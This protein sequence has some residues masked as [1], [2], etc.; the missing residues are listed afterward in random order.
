MSKVEPVSTSDAATASQAFWQAQLASHLAALFDSADPAALAELQAETEWVALRS[1][2]VLFRRGDPGSAAYTVLSGRLRVIDDTAG[3]RALNEIGA[4]EIL[5]EMALLSA[6]RRSATVLAV[7]DSLLARL[8]AA[9]FHRLIERQPAVLR[10]ISALLVDRLRQQSAAGGRARPVVRT[11]AVV[12]ASPG[13]DTEGFVRRLVGAL[14]LHGATLH[15][16]A[17]LVDRAL[18]QDGIAR[19]AEQDP[20]SPRLVQWLNEQEL[21]HRFVLY[22]TDALFSNWTERAVRQADHVVFV[23]DAAAAPEPG[24]AELDERSGEGLV[25]EAH[26]VDIAHGGGR[27]PGRRTEQ[28][29]DR[30]LGRIAADP[31]PR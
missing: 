3:E 28:R 14:A 29:N 22:E 16:D 25:V 1:G 18:G 5:G 24:D 9:A 17:R 11:L 2:D 10:R 12:P 30:A 21:A 6:E 13:G 23:A 4:G 15:L 8:P 26:P 19:C 27:H 20:A 31:P 7:R